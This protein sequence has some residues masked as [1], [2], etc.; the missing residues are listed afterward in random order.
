MRR[1]QRYITDIK[2]LVA[3]LR[4]LANGP[5]KPQNRSDGRDDAG[6]LLPLGLPYH[7]VD[8]FL[9]FHKSPGYAKAFRRRFLRL[10]ELQ[11]AAREH[12]AASN[13]GRAALARYHLEQ[14]LLRRHLRWLAS[15]FEGGQISTGQDG[16]TREKPKQRRRRT[17]R[18]EL[19]P[20]T[21]KQQEALDLKKKVGKT[22]EQIG[23]H[24]GTTKQAA[25]RLLQRAE[26]R[27]AEL[28]TVVCS[29][30][31]RKLRQFLDSDQPA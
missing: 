31:R 3:A 28:D 13:R 22:V 24:F 26:K 21:K 10:L 20:L 5:V 11:K 29:V 4:E 16:Q 19:K 8:A 25:S 17:K 9:Q 15:M 27:A 18:T 12:S 7:D 14:Y 2:G 1:R 30:G 6:T 23:A